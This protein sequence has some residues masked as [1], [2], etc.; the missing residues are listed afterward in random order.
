[1][2]SLLCFLGEC[3]DGGD[4][5]FVL[6]TV[7]IAVAVT[8][9]VM[10]TVVVVTVVCVTGAVA[11]VVA[12]S[13]AVAATFTSAACCSICAR[14]PGLAHGVCSFIRFLNALLVV[15][16]VLSNRMDAVF[17]EMLVTVPV[18]PALLSAPFVLRTTLS[19]TE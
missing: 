3:I 10:V 14:T 4:L 18:S 1:L 12:I 7:A 8:V 17:F 2:S 16:V 11:V 6:S 15:P 13:A 5:S 19:P 9:I